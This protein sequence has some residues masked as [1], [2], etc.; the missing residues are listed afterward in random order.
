MY[1]FLIVLNDQD[2]RKILRSHDQS[3]DI[4]LLLQDYSPNQYYL[5][6][7][8]QSSMVKK[9]KKKRLIAILGDKMKSEFGKGLVICLLKFANHFNNDIAKHIRH[10]NL[11]LSKT[12]EERK[13]MLSFNPP[14]NLNYG[15][16]VHD[17][18]RYFVEST[19]EIF[20][21]DMDKAISHEITLWANG[22]SD[23]LYEIKVPK[24]E[25]WNKVRE[26]VCDLKD[27]G[28]TMGHSFID[29]KIYKL[30]DFEY[31]MSLT[32]LIGLEIDKVI[33]LKP[34]IGTWQ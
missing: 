27:K 7:R 12:E 24:C 34:E 32:F 3:V 13:K 1:I 29:N 20:D 26:M 15:K 4:N 17:Y 21:N 23:H 33:E 5:S 6:E 11:Y 25:K 19:K 22:A 10:I 28:I 18:L 9:Q 14:D 16:D 31:L 30:E 2:T 8:P